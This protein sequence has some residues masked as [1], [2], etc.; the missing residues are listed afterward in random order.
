[1]YS[2]KNPKKKAITMN[3]LRLVAAVLSASNLLLASG[4]SQ[5]HGYRFGYPGYY[6]P[7]PGLRGPQVIY[8]ATVIHSGSRV[9]HGGVYRGWHGGWHGGYYTPGLPHRSSIA[10]ALAL[11][12]IGGGLAGAALAAPPVVNY[13]PTAVYPS[14]M[15][16]PPTAVHPPA[17]VSNAPLA[18]GSGS[19]VIAS[20]PPPSTIS[21]P[22][23][24]AA[25]PANPSAS[26]AMAPGEP[27]YGTV[28]SSLPPGC[29]FEP[30]NNQS[31]YR[32]SSYWYQAQ[33]GPQGPQYVFV[34]PPRID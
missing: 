25:P 12:V 17:V 32:C 23:L 9:W 4:A 7:G 8:N 18:V 11:G 13:P 30:L 2:V 24:A 15:V 16:Y 3:C 27:A 22:A 21:A 33:F 20:A 31:Y 34:A 10:G 5:A 14:A 19:T 29:V 26:L 28:Y 1:V 6:V